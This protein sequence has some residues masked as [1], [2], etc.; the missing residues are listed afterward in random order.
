MRAMARR[1]RIMLVAAHPDDEIIGA[2]I[3]MTRWIPGQV[4]F[5]HA[6]DGSPLDSR[7]AQAAGFETREEYASERR[8]EL[9]EALRLAGMSEARC[10][11][12]GF[13]DQQAHLHLP[14]LVEKL[15]ELIDEIRPAI[16]Y[17]H[18]YEG[19]H[20]DH[21]AVALAVAH[22]SRPRPAVWEFTSYHAGVHGVVRGGF[23]QSGAVQT[24]LLTAPERALKLEM[25]Q[26]FR[27]Q[28]PV[29]R[30]FPIVE[31]KFRIAPA[32]DFTKPPHPGPLHYET[33]GWNITGEDWRRSASEVLGTL[34]VRTQI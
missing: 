30:D 18:P 10:V 23:L 32:Y 6:T 8:R 22:A 2:G 9:G 1:S 27:S 24:N 17:T 20:P 4:T 28:E 26:C 29:L 3:Q 12:L 7:H 19:G 16:I 31:E 5:V 25:F 33:L 15:A 11:E 13:I 34:K 14:E 21:D